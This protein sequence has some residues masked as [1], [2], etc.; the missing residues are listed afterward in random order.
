M[1]YC[2]NLCILLKKMEY[3]FPSHVSLT[4]LSTRA[5]QGR[6]AEKQLK[7]GIAISNELLVDI[8]VEAIR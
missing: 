5:L 3:S 1:F 4:Q 2:K 6:A 8:I 7:N